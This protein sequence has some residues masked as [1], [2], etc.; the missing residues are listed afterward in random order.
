MVRPERRWWIRH[1]AR[2]RAGGRGRLRDA[3]RAAASAGRRGVIRASLASTLALATVTSIVAA[4]LVSRSGPWPP[5]SVVLLASA[6][7][8]LLSPLFWPR[9]SPGL[10]G[11]LRILFAQAFASLAVAGTLWAFFGDAPPPN[12]LVACVLLALL[13]CAA[14]YPLAAL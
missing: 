3:A 12:R 4:V 13:V 10:A 7:P 2:R 6:V 8:L 9:E 5:S 1:H 14:L 11:L